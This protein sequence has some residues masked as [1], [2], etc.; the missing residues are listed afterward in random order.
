VATILSQ[1]AEWI[2]THNYAVASSAD[3]LCES[4]HKI[5]PATDALIEAGLM[6]HG[7]WI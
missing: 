2:L 3:L 7:C 4:S 6:S 5:N 1:R